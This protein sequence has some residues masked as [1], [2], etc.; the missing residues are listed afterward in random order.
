M[1]KF[2]ALEQLKDGVSDS[3]K[4]KMNSKTKHDPVD[5]LPKQLLKTSNKQVRLTINDDPRV[6]IE[7]N[8][9]ANWF[10]LRYHAADHHR[11]F[12]DDQKHSSLHTEA[13]H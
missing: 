9:R 12:T 1:I 2:L 6:S 11:S 5:L 3:V 13:T 8:P 4:A 7:E 10:P